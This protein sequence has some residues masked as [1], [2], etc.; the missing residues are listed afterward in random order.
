MNAKA[1]PSRHVPALDGLRGI[2]ILLVLLWHSAPF[3]Q[4]FLPGWSG[5]DLFF[6]LSGYLITG[7]LLGTKGRPHYFSGFFRNRALRI[8]PLYYAVV[9]GFLL[10]VH[11]FVQPKNLPE[12]SLYTHHWQDFALFLQN[13]PIVFY[14]LPRNPSL[15]PLWSLAVEEQFYLVWP[16]VILL[17]PSPRA[18]FRTF[19]CLIIIIM[20]ARTICY[21]HYPSL[22]TSNYFNTFF[23]VDSLIIGALLC[24]LHTAGTKIPMQT[25]RI[26]ALALLML[27]ITGNALA[28]SV[29]LTNL[30]NGTIG[31]TLFAL[32]FA[33]VMHLCILPG[34]R[35]M[36]RFFENP[37]L[38]FCGKISYGLYILHSPIIQTA[39]T[40]MVYW[41]I[42]RWPGYD[43]LIMT[44]SMTICLLLTFALATLS[45]RYF[46][47]WFLQYKSR[48][49]RPAGVAPTHST[50]S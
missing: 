32:L 21:L 17:L 9:T 31:Y 37:F 19:T 5:V 33:C 6:V 47:S 28:K 23:R 18:S 45:F 11:L 29:D 50:I 10:V 49:A 42:S 38:R 26:L 22:H 12:F 48:P 30:F 7:R 15:A 39:G 40:K 3:T 44:L 8:L 14:G 34:N 1:I 25:A 36:T 35:A 16:F 20:A 46:E 41:G 13:W 24:Q 27:I 43:N 2:A 4:S